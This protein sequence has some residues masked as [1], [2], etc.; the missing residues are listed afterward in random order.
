[1][2]LGTGTT[3]VLFG[4]Y[5]FG[6]VSADWGYFAQ[7]LVQQSLNSREDFKPGTGTNLNL[8][9]RYTA[10]ATFVPQLQITARIEK[11]EQGAEADV[12]NSGA[13]WVYE[14]RSDVE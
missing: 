6:A 8:G 13:T 10:S 14:S 12:E 9:V 11:R 7:A 1:M 4:V 5:N 2:Q 3:D